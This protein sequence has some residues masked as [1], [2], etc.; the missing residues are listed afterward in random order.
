MLGHILDPCHFHG[1]VF[2]GEDDTPFD[3]P[4][5]L[6]R[7]RA[8]IIMAVFPLDFEFLW[9]DNVVEKL[10]HRVLD[11]VEIVVNDFSFGVNV[12]HVF[13]A[14]KSDQTGVIS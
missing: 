2:S 4:T 1:I 7:A 14:G 3:Y 6:Q 10:R 12:W 13:V 9:H 5:G 11:D 8:H